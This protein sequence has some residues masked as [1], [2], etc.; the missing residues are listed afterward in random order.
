MAALG[1]PHTCESAHAI[2]TYTKCGG[3]HMKPH[4]YLVREGTQDSCYQVHTLKGPALTNHS[5]QVAHGVE[6]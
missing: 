3:V 1:N 2:Q 4:S 5:A 6:K